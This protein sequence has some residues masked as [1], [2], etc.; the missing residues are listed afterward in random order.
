MRIK[1]GLGFSP[2]Q[3]SDNS[4]PDKIRQV[5]YAPF[6]G[7]F[8]RGLFYVRRKAEGN[9]WIIGSLHR[10]QRVTKID[11]AQQI[12]LDVF[13]LTIHHKAYGH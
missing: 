3:F 8:K 4:L 1:C 7:Q 12:T 6:F 2:F 9:L 13:C 11:G 5:L 10:F